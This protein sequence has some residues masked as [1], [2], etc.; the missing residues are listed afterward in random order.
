M[1]IEYQRPPT[2]E[3]ALR[4]LGREKPVSRAMG[5]GTVLNQPSEE[6]YA[7]V[8]LQALGLD[9]LQSRGNTLVMGATLK[10]QHLLEAEITSPA[11]RTVIQQQGSPNLRRMAS[12]AGSL[13]SADG[14]SPFAV[15]MLALDASLVW[16]P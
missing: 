13:V 4:L 14:R 2:I 11:L 8:D 6:Q 1:I 15:A 5:G 10:L 9:Q 16:L 12:V 3:A 7:V